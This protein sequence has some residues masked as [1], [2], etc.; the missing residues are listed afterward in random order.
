MNELKKISAGTSL[1]WTFEHDLADGTWQFEYILRGQSAIAIAAS[2]E[3]GQVTFIATA[4]TTATW[5]AGH[6]DWRLYASKGDEKHVIESGQLEIEPDFTQ[7]QAEYDPRSHA[8]RMLDAINTVLEGRILSD[9]E[10]YSIDGRSLDRIPIMELHK[11]RRSYILKFSR[12]NGS[13]FRIK[14]VLARLPE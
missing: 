1:N 6:Y 5:I 12:E 11:L 10:R 4:S 14:R 8:K 3:N 13:G 2:A 9:H 7:V